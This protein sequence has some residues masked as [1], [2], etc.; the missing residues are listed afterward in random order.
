MLALEITLR[1][2]FVLFCLCCVLVCG[3]GQLEAAVL[4][5]GAQPQQ[6]GADRRL[7][8]APE[9][10]HYPV[11]P[12]LDLL[13]DPRGELT[14]DDVSSP[15]WADHFAPAPAES[16]NFGFTDAAIW[17]RLRIE[18]EVSGP[19]FLELAYPLL[20]HVSVYVQQGDGRMHY[21]TGD[22][23][24]FDTRLLQTRLFVFPLDLGADRPTTVYVRVRST[25][26]VTLPIDL[27]SQRRLLQQITT[28]YGILALY[29]GALLMLM[30]YNLHHYVRLKDI[31]ALYYVLFIGSF[32]GFQLALNGISFQYLWP[33][34]VWWANVN[35]PFFISASYLTAILFTRSILN[36]AVN[37]PLIHR[38]LGWLR[39]LAAAGMLLALISPY[40]W[41]VEFAVG[42]IFTLIF[43]IAAGIQSMLKGYRPARYYAA[44]WTVSLG[45]MIIYAMKT[46]GLLPTTFWTTWI[47]QIGSTWDAIILAFAISDRFYLL[48][49]EKR[50]VQ[51]QAAA[52]LTDSNRQLNQLNEELESRVSAGLRELRL[53]NES[54]RAEAEVRRQAEL[55]AEAASRAKSEFLANMSHEIRTPMNAVVGFAQILSRS[56]LSREQRA[57]VGKV[58]R[59]AGDLLDIIEDI[60]DFSKIE[61]GRIELDEAPFDLDDVVQRVRELVE[62]EAARKDLR[63]EVS[64]EGDTDCRLLGDEGRLRQVL[65]NLLSNAVKFTDRGHVRLWL[66]CRRQGERRVR[67]SVAVEDTGIGISP[68]Q[69][70]RLFEPFT[71]ADASI[72]RRFGGT[73]L[74]LTICRRLISAMG[75]T[76]R[77]ESGLGQGS[78]FSFDLDLEPVED[79]Q[80]LPS[81]EDPAKPHG[82]DLQGLRVL[83]VEDQDLNQE[84]AIA[85]L[86]AA[87]AVIEVAENGA[88]ALDRLHAKGADAFDLVL[89]D[90]QMPVMDGY[91][92]A[93]QIRRD[94]GFRDLPIIAMT[95]HALSGERARCHA[96]GMNDHIA[97]P[98][99]MG[100]LCQVLRRWCRSERTTEPPS[101]A[102]TPSHARSSGRSVPTASAEAP[103]GIDGAAL[104]D[105]DV[106]AGRGRVGGQAAHCRLLQ[107]FAR[108]H[109]DHAGR[110][111]GQLGD[112]DP[113]AARQEA[114]AL[115]GVA[116]N[117]VPLFSVCCKNS[118]LGVSPR[119]NCEEVLP[120]SR[121]TL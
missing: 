120:W 64:R 4:G 61:A 39:Y 68:E 76:L 90:L 95:A 115:A 7:V 78:R 101:A 117:L 74:G 34:N 82:A 44:A 83:L 116:L 41:A 16:P 45:A 13:Q 109:A 79:R 14:I 27:L 55:T 1:A 88:E 22:R 53:S 111:R 31:N 114:H 49:E 30:V 84:I 24:P 110:I 58:Q 98:I 108:D 37:A 65:A 42:I 35:L 33:N 36:T 57:W 15:A 5:D 48:Q 67:L 38:I 91:E 87:G 43:F 96:A 97:K 70:E 25:G 75:G 105:I 103:G 20:D 80:H 59:A 50:R 29:F 52:E 104:P 3:A 112:G 102:G 107:R 63:L 28:D 86:S 92:A 71:Q 85:I 6:D 17:A 106:E 118:S 47:T 56:D 66:D 40:R 18:S 12:Y 10:D 9:T 113:A 93:R 81:Q 89:M 51:A 72:A 73:G 60:L 26:S 69:Q 62:I 54:L 8:V 77:V 46:Y 94:P 19:Y 119:V 2:S 32:L 21:E 99:E 121:S 11:G 100:R 23:T